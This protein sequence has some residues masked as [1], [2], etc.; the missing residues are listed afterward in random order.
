MV[1]GQSL[2]A[3]ASPAAY[4]L[5]AFSVCDTKRRCS[6]CMR[7]V[8]R[9]VLYALDSERQHL[10]SATRRFLVV[11]LCRLSTLGPRA[12]SVAGPSL[13]NSLSD[14][15]RDPDL[16]RDTSDVCQRG[17]YL[18]CTEAFSALE[19]CQDDTLYKLTSLLSHSLTYSRLD[20]CGDRQEL[21]QRSLRHW[22]IF[23]SKVGCR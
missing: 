20:S 2:W 19:M 17:I 10:R 13:C 6:C 9:Y 11:S 4:R 14:S 7:L 3:Q 8:W 18:H 21:P 16:G 12:F 22:C 5:Y 1:T 15:L 23:I